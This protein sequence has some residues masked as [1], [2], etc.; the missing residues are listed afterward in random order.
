MLADRVQRQVEGH[1]PRIFE[2]LRAEVTIFESRLSWSYFRG[3][4][5]EPTH[6]R[7]SLNVPT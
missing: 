4:R 1:N 5:L 6:A 3:G 2:T 7:R